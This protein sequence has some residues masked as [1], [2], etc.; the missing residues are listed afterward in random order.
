MPEVDPDDDTVTR[1]VVWH[2]R[3][4]PTRRQRRNV[5][6][7]AYDDRIEFEDRVQELS[8]ALLS[9]KAAGKA[10]SGEDISGEVR[11]PGHRLRAQ[12]AR[13]LT[14]AFSRG[15]WPPHW[16]RDHPP[17]GVSLVSVVIDRPD[18][19]HE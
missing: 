4:D 19:E 12:N 2:Y 3:Y 18:G 14:R 6:V 1:Y 5:L 9:R 13:L 8:G 17:D 10:E 7:A 16:D 15:V 11:T